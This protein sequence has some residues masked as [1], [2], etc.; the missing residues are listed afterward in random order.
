M[1][2]GTARPAAHPGLCPGPRKAGRVRGSSPHKR[3]G[4]LGPGGRGLGSEAAACAG[5]LSSASPVS[6][7]QNCLL[8]GEALKKPAT[9]THRP[10]WLP[11]PGGPPGP[12]APP[13]PPQTEILWPSAG[14]PSGFPA[15]PRPG[16][17]GSSCVPQLVAPAQPHIRGPISRPQRS[18]AASLAFLLHVCLCP[19]DA[20]EEEEEDEAGKAGP[21]AARSAPGRVRT[22]LR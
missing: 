16:E 12:A 13:V 7:P 6:G 14:V 19:E 2:R 10:S 1:G 11:S 3:G 18:P 8:P 22:V 5:H 9:S 4:P 21:L 20:E 17:E 15:I